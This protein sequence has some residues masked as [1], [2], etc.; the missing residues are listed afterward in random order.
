M[1]HLAAYLDR[2]G[3]AGPLRSDFETLRALHRAHL[4]AERAQRSN[5][6]AQHEIDRACAIADEILIEV[7][8][9]RDA[10][11]H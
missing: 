7:R 9:S 8:K 1:M 11:R 10:G 5:K 2:I 3:Y 4:L 6:T